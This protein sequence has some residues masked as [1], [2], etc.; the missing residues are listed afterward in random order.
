MG[1]PGRAC[2]STLCGSNVSNVGNGK[3]LELHAAKLRF[4]EDPTRPGALVWSVAAAALSC[5]ASIP[6]SRNKI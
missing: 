6:Q 2:L 1:S 5:E 3:R 4:L